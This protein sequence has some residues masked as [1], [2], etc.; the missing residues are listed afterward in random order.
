MKS[1]YKVADRIIMLDDGKILANGDA[2]SIRQS[3]HPRVQQFINGQLSSEDLLALK[4]GKAG[5]I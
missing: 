3:T 2:D 4:L 5:N 1:A